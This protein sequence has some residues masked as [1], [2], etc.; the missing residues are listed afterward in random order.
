[1]KRISK[2]DLVYY[3]FN[4]IDVFSGYKVKHLF[5]FNF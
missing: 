1:M 4:V 3:T 5:K 2:I